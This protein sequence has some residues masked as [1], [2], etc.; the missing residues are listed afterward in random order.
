MLHENVI[1]ELK[2]K[3]FCDGKD[4]HSHKDTSV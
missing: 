2:D 1:E 3:I 4:E